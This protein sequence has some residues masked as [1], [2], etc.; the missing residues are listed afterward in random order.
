[1]YMYIITLKQMN[2]ISITVKKTIVQHKPGVLLYLQ[3]PR[4]V[5]VGVGIAY[6][7]TLKSIG[8]CQRCNHRHHARCSLDQLRYHIRPTGLDQRD[9]LAARMQVLCSQYHTHIQ[10]V[11]QHPRELNIRDLHEQQAC[12][13]ANIC[14]YRCSRWDIPFSGRRYHRIQESSYIHP[15]Y[16]YINPCHCTLP[17]GVSYWRRSLRRPTTNP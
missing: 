17:K 2:M 15:S 3:E 11:W 10:H 14:L 4:A 6:H 5:Y 13:L 9:T 7:R 1:M 8:R 16:D 12:I